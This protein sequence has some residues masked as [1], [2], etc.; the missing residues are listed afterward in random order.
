MWVGPKLIIHD[1]EYA[2][3]EM[4]LRTLELVPAA[5]KLVDNVIP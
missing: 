2:L 1:K 4:M 5:K 3:L